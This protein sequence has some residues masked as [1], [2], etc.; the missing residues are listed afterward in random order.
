MP[1]SR[2]AALSALAAVTGCGL[3]VGPYQP[4][5]DSYATAGGARPTLDFSDVDRR[6]AHQAAKRLTL[7]ERGGG[8]TPMYAFG[9]GY[10]VGVKQ[11]VSQTR[12]G[13]AAW[14]GNLYAF[15]P[16]A[17]FFHTLLADRLTLATSV[18]AVGYG[19]GDD[20]SAAVSRYIAGGV[21][22]AA[23]V[24]VTGSLAL[25]LAAG[26][27]H[28]S[29]RYDDGAAMGD[30]APVGAWRGAAGL[31]WVMMRIRGNDLVLTTEVQQARTGEVTLLA[32]P[33]SIDARALMFEL[34]L[35]G[36]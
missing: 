13:D 1:V 9:G 28:G 11:G 23:K 22:L 24:G 29:A 14:S 17:G 16:H 30:S 25:R 20:S 31:D 27:L 8:D 5:R 32:Q 12:S 26:R 35:V 18:L 7:P 6:A 36:I 19:T 4:R 10:Y 15:E 34:V 2:V 21:E 33:R 3:G